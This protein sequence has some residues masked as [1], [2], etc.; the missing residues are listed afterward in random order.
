MKWGNFFNDVFATKVHRE[1][2]R[3]EFVGSTYMYLHLIFG[4]SVARFTMSSS[5]YLVELERRIISLSVA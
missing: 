3:G 2:S 5:N 1:L 4:Y